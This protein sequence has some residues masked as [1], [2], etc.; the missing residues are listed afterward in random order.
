M[1]MTRVATVSF[2]LAMLAAVS[3]CERRPTTA[4]EAPAAKADFA[5]PEEYEHL[6][7]AGGEAG[8]EEETAPGLSGS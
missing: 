4:P 5:P 6:A 1:T 7:G 3:G 2:A 8:G